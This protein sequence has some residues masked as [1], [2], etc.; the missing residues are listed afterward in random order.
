MSLTRSFSEK[1]FFYK[2]F[3]WKFALL[4]LSEENIYD[5]YI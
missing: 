4:I 5:D 1:S 3:G 2:V